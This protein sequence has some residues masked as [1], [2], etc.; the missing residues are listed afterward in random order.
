M[1]ALR[2]RMV[3]DMQLRCFAQKTQEAYLRAVRQTELFDQVP[4]AVW[5]QD[6]VVHCQ[7]VDDGQATLKYLAPYIFRVALYNRRILNA[8]KTGRSPSN[9]PTGDR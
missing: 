2:K 8:Q 5:Q 6:W 7:P 1:T 4:A 3:E 9:T